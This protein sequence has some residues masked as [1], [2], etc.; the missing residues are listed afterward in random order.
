MMAATERERGRWSDIEEG[1]VRLTDGDK[2]GRK[3]QRGFHGVVVVEELD[4]WRLQFKDRNATTESVDVHL[5]ASGGPGGGL[6]GV[7]GD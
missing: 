6:S 7:H 1:G 3:Q 5:G 4:L 2:D